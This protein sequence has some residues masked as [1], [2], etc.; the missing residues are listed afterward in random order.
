MYNKYNRKR[1]RAIRASDKV[2]IEFKKLAAEN[3]VPLGDMLEILVENYKI[4]KIK[5]I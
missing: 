3:R 5:L 1:L 2:W 4:Y